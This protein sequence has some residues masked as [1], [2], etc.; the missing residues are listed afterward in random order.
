MSEQKLNNYLLLMA[1]SVGLFV[2]FMVSY[3]SSV[4]TAW[5]KSRAIEVG[6]AE[7]NTKTGKFQWSDSTVKY[8]VTGEWNR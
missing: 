7:Y 5:M 8:I 3:V 4:P 6:A 2:G 1:L